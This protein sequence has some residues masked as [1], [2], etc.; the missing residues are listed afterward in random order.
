MLR[1]TSNMMNSQLMLNLNRNARSMNNTQLQLSTGRKVNKPSD[2]PV[3][4]TYSLRYRTELNANDQYRSNV[5]SALSWLDYNDTAVGQV[6]DIIKRLKDLTI[7]ASNSTNPQEALTGIQTEVEQLKEQLIDIGNSKL[8]GKYIFNGQTYDKKPYDFPKNAN[9][10]SDTSEAD[11]VKTDPGTVNFIV[12]ESVQLPIS[13]TGDSIFGASGDD[14]H[15]FV[16]ID[17]LTGA[18]STS[19][20]DTISAQLDKL[21]TRMDKVLTVRAEIGA[22]TNR[23]ELMA[24][25]LEDM[26]INLTDL[27]SKAEDAD[28]EKLIIQSKI[29]ESIY[30]ASL[31][32]GAKIIS[33]SLVDFMR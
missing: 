11:K 25:R 10:L 30:N 16:M 23:V 1:V 4:M 27:Q 20:F 15:L 22:K 24:G 33:T 21:D 12:G 29:Q 2:D 6:G 17:R 7:Q 18:L 32:V 3:A 8:N 9:H 19:D 31:S 26:G 28:Y 14:D 5:D 13:V